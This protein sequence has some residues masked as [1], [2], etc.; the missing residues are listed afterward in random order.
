MAKQISPALL[1]EQAER[2]FGF[3]LPA[4][5]KENDLK[6]PRSLLYQAVA[7]EA[8]KIWVQN[9]APAVQQVIADKNPLTIPTARQTRARS[10]APSKTIDEST[11]D[12]NIQRELATLEV[13]LSTLN[14]RIQTLQGNI[15]QKVTA[16]R[17]NTQQLTSLVPQTPQAQHSPRP[18][19]MVYQALQREWTKT[20]PKPGQKTANTDEQ[21]A[22]HLQK[23]FG[24]NYGTAQPILDQVI[25]RLIEISVLRD[26]LV[27]QLTRH[28]AVSFKISAL[29]N[30][31]TVR[32]EP[33]AVPDYVKE[34]ARVDGYDHDDEAQVSMANTGPAA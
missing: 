3:K 17:N 20:Q 12:A 9:T 21:E 27:Q 19:H 7:T 1:A 5:I 6:N 23:T 14:A 32:P 15:Q 26:T 22:D 31:S 34:A 30:I 24:A 13:E 8:A 29:R 11:T 2:Q 16:S 28:E 33:I 10:S 25:R 18:E 4:Q